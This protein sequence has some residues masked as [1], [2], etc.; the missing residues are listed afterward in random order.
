MLLTYNTERM[1]P[2]KSVPAQVGILDLPVELLI[3]ILRYLHCRDILRAQ[4]VRT[5]L[6]HR[7]AHRELTAAQVCRHLRDIVA[8]S[9]E[10]RY[11]IELAA[12]N[13][14][15]GS[16]KPGSSST[17]ERLDLLLDRRRRWRELNWTR[18][19]TVPMPGQCQAY[20]LVGGTFA[21]SMSESPV[22]GSRHLNV[23]W[24]PTRN[25]EHKAIVRDN[26]GVPTKDF[27][28]DP[29]Q[30]LIALVEMDDQ[31]V[32]NLVPSHA[33]ILMSVP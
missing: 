22:M 29:S 5:N 3:E 9:I 32:C 26:L 33:T 14:I 20:E 15:D 21:K 13:L 28:I 24:L 18:Q 19:T 25:E 23:T 31:Y 7:L 11:L 17:R 10:L 12:D 6:F 1:Q 30:D 8:G 4:A 27:A 16:R 2:C